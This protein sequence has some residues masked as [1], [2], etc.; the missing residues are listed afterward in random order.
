MLTAAGDSTHTN[1]FALVA[2]LGLL[3]LRIFEVVT[4]IADLGEGHGHR[5]LTMHGKGDR[6]DRIP[7]PP[8]VGR[9]LDRAIAGRV[10]GPLLRNTRGGWMDCHAATCDCNTSPTPAESRSP[11]CTPTCC[12]TSSSPPCSTPASSQHGDGCVK[13]RPLRRRRPSLVRRSSLC[14]CDDLALMHVMPMSGQP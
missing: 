12:G 4:N 3:G 9:A 10:D 13:L 7:L 6:V 14:R 5:V 11:A 8:A 2:L 1:D